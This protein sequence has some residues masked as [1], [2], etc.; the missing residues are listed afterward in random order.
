M[1]DGQSVQSLQSLQS[2]QLL[3]AT[4]LWS[5]FAAILFFVCSF[6]LF[7]LGFFT[8]FFLVTVCFFFEDFFPRRF[9]FFVRHELQPLRHKTVLGIN[10][11]RIEK[12]VSMVQRVDNMATFL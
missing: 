7:L 9:C 5:A 8:F 3:H 12:S 6:F 2:V 4:Q 10:S 1:H 11:A